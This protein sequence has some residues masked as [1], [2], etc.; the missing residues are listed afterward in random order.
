MGGHYSLQTRG[1]GSYDK[2]RNLLPHE[3]AA[4]DHALDQ[5]DVLPIP[6]VPN[7]AS[8]L[9]NG[10][11]DNITLLAQALGMVGNTA[12]LDAPATPRSPCRLA[13]SMGYL[14]E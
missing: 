1:G 6:T 3:R 4:Y 13:S 11:E 10:S 12:P 7:S 9:P 2:A 14:S 8:S 5:Y